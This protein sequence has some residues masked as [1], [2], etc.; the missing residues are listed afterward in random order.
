MADEVNMAEGH[1]EE[2]DLQPM[3][4]VSTWKPLL[5][6]ITRACDEALVDQFRNISEAKREYVLLAVQNAIDTATGAIEKEMV[7]N[8]EAAEIVKALGV[9]RERLVEILPQ[10]VD[11]A[12]LAKSLAIEQNCEPHDIAT[13]IKEKDLEIARLKMQLA[14]LQ[15][16]MAVPPQQPVAP[17]PPQ[18]P[19]AP[20]PPQ[21]QA[22]LV[23]PQQPAAPQ[24]PRQPAQPNHP[25]LVRV[26]QAERWAS[27][28]P[29]EDLAQTITNIVTELFPRAPAR[30]KK[31]A[32]RMQPNQNLDFELGAKLYECLSEWADSYHM[33]AALEAP[34]GRVFEEVQKVALRLE[35]TGETSKMWNEKNVERKQH[36][37]KPMSGKRGKDAKMYDE[38]RPK[39]QLNKEGKPPR[40]CFE[41]GEA[42]HFADKC[43]KRHSKG[44]TNQGRAP[45]PPSDNRELAGPARLMKEKRSE[46]MSFSTHLN[47]WCLKVRKDE[48][49]NPTAAYGKPCYCDIELLGVKAKALIDTGSVISIIPVGLLKRAQHAGSD[50]DEMVTMM[51]DDDDVQVYDASGNPMEFLMRIALEIKV[52]GAGRA[53]TQLYIQQSK[54]QLVLLGTN[55]LAALGIEVKLHPEKDENTNNG[56]LNASIYPKQTKDQSKPHDITARGVHRVLIPPFTIGEVEISSGQLEGDQVFWSQDDRI[57]PGVCRISKGSAK[58][59][60][61]NQGNEPWVVRKGQ[62]MGTWTNDQWYDPKTADIPGDML[63]MQRPELIPLD[64]KADR[65]LEILVSNR[66][67]GG[68]PQ[69]TRDLIT[70]YADAFAVSDVELTQT[71]L[72]EHDIDVQGHPPIKQKTRPVPYGLRKEVEGMLKDLEDRQIIEESTSPWASPIVLVAKKDGG[73]RLCV[74]YREVN[75]VTKKECYPLPA[76]DVTLQNLKEKQ[77]FTSLDLASG[78]WQVPL[79]SKAREISAFTTTAGQYQ[80]RVIPFGLTNAPSAFQRLMKKVLDSLLGSEVSVYID[81]VLIATETLERHFEVLEKVFQAFQRANLK[82]KPKSAV[83]WRRK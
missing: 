52:Q 3:E 45:N 74:D 13:V 47:S 46:K 67:S 66:K 42:G 8:S 23:P 59:S 35:R 10:L 78:Y 64:Q 24:P 28:E 55:V 33:L 25:A 20:E 79:T 43:P 30:L 80:F 39:F 32:T 83:F 21:Q 71:H 75:K 22:V 70:K 15:D 31:I 69:Q 38:P 37:G 41:C 11:Y 57:A 61:A 53:K 48:S 76:I 2:Q 56:N 49:D 5:S 9:P 1:N 17:E 54:D 34:E 4:V 40:V 16:E 26:R 68:F 63:E 18:Q 65:V 77:Y 44:K 14:K 73:I 60:V 82:I 27:I 58:I 36:I 6:N 81:D 12:A 51:E 19:V 7:H 62:L 29:E 72:M 50:L